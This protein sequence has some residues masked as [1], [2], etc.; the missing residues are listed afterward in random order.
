[1]VAGPE[2]SA[3]S[4]AVSETLRSTKVLEEI[5]VFPLASADAP[6]SEKLVCGATVS[7]TGTSTTN[8]DKVFPMYVIELTPTEVVSFFQPVP[9]L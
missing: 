5:Y 9:S 2:T 8:G 1:M 7:S 6:I 3:G 4:S